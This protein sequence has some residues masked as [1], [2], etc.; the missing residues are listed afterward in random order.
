MSSPKNPAF[1]LCLAIGGVICWSLATPCIKGLP[2][3]IP[4]LL[5]NGIRA[6]IGAAVLIIGALC[7][8]EQSWS[9]KTTGLIAFTYSIFTLGYTF[10]LREA[11][12]IAVL[13]IVVGLPQVIVIAHELWKGKADHI[14]FVFVLILVVLCALLL[15]GQVDDQTEL[16]GLLFYR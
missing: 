6:W 16:E 7:V 14:D 13:S 1:G 9:L 15:Y 11:D 12:A 2:D 3:E 5:I 10:A 4:L 8:K